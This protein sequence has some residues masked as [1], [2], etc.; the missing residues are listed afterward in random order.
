MNK[1]EIKRIYK[2]LCNYESSYSLDM[3]IGDDTTDGFFKD[4]L[5]EAETNE[6]DKTKLHQLY[7]DAICETHQQGFIDGFTYACRLFM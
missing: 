2:G 3:R 6:Q 7:I 1:E 5:R 4:A